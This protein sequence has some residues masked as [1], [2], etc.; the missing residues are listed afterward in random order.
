[1]EGIMRL[2][3]KIKAKTIA[4]PSQPQSIAIVPPHTASA[5]V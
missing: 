5:T 3:D 1:M 2:Q 4:I